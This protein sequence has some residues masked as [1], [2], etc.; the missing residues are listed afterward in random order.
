MRAERALKVFLLRAGDGR[1]VRTVTGVQT[2][3]LPICQSGGAQQCLPGDRSAGR[4][5]ILCLLLHA[6]EPKPIAVIRRR[7]RRRIARS[8]ERRV[9]KE[10]R[11]WRAEAPEKKKTDPRLHTASSRQTRA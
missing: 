8:E 7:R 10:G 4:A 2:C 9:G 11:S 5:V 1:R 3:A 6:P